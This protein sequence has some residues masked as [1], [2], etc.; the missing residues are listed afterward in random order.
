MK[1]INLLLASAILLLQTLSAFSQTE[2]KKEIKLSS[3]SL[4]SG[5][6]PLSNGVFAEANF[7]RGND[8]IN[9]SISASDMY[10]VYLKGIGKRI[11]VGPSFEYFLNVP[12][13]GIMGFVAPIQREKFSITAM[14]WSGV[15]AGIP[16]EKVQPF[17][18]GFR[19]FWQSLDFSYSRFTATGAVLYYDSWGP[20]VDFKYKQPLTPKWNIF[21]SAG[22]S[23]YCDG[24]ALLKLGITYKP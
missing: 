22:Y 23:W 3:I 19:F 24:K 9:I 16:G 18:W 12:V 14:T 6:G 10:I 7:A 2:A 13:M 1:R 21:A 20:L 11:S 5:E 17:N 15:S 8:V 4:S